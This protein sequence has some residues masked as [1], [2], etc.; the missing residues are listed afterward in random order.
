MKWNTNVSP[1]H[2]IANIRRAQAVIST[3][4]QVQQQAS[5]LVPQQFVQQS[6]YIQ[7]NS[8]I[9][10]QQIAQSRLMSPQQQQVHMIHQQQH[11]QKMSPQTVN[12]HNYHNQMNVSPSVNYH[13]QPQQFNQHQQLLMQQ[14]PQQ[15][16]PYLIHNQHNHH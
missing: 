3:P 13:Q 4:L 2:I 12:S 10:N 5:P 6:H 8:P 15:Q 11:Q 16:Q 7:H 14:Q 9:L 1:S